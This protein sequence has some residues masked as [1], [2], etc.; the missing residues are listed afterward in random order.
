MCYQSLI[1]SNQ[2]GFSFSTG[3]QYILLSLLANF[4]KNR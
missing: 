2:E 1:T 4:N 3:D